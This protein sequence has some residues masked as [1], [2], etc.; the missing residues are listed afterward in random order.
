M[1]FVNPML[2]TPLINL[3][4]SFKAN[5]GEFAGWIT[6]MDFGDPIKEVIE[7]RNN[8][9]I[10]DISHM[11]RIKLEGKDAFKLLDFLVPKD[12]SKIIEGAM[13]G[14]TA[15]L[16]E[17]AG[18]KDDVMLY[19]LSENEWFIV[20]N[21]VNREKILNWLNK[22]KTKLSYEVNIKDETFNLALIAL[23]G[24]KAP[25]ILELLGGRDAVNLKIMNF[26]RNVK[27]VGNETFLISRSGWT[28]E[29]VRSAGYEIITTPKHA[30]QIFKKAIELGAIPAGLIAR[31]ILRS[32][33]GY[34]LYGEDINEETNPLE[35]RYWVFTKGKTDC[36]G[37]DELSNI[38]KN[39]VSKIRIGFRLKKGVRIIPRHGYKVYI[40]DVNIGYVTSGTFSPTLN[41]SIAM[42]Y[43]NSSHALIGLEVEIN[44]RGKYYKAK[45]V[46][47]P[48]IKM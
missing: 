9:T 39:G 35:A 12:L 44:I 3:H 29:E 16:N 46:D 48:F 27:V 47:F 10:F 43:V 45:I 30:E 40:D 23:Q 7:T 15:F 25:N 18:F 32:E 19:K 38:I 33:M 13:S 8:V 22:W 28:G 11:G 20:C 4:K 6:A 5:L 37:C 41:R 14:P 34:V 21:A 1:L 24:P 31:D 36:I 26:I 42:G 17:K 2:K